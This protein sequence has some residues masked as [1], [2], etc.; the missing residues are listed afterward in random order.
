VGLLVLAFTW[1]GTGI[2]WIIFFLNL[3]NDI[4]VAFSMLKL[5]SPIGIIFG[6]FFSILLISPNILAN[7]S[8]GETKIRLRATYK[9]EIF[10]NLLELILVFLLNL[11]FWLPTSLLAFHDL[12][13]K[14]KGAPYGAGGGGYIYKERNWRKLIGDELR[15]REGEQ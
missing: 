8:R 11:L 6:V 13:E 7:K 10:K 12:N 15:G 2:F 1:V 3:F 14:R 4:E 5:Y 9:K